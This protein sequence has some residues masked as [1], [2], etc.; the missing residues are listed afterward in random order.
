M[1]SKQTP[2]DL[3][4]VLYSDNHLLALHKPPMLVTQPTHGHKINLEEW[5]KAWIRKKTNKPGE[6]FLHAVH[7]L[8]RE[9]QGIVLFARTSKALSRLNEAMRQGKIRKTYLAVV[10]GHLEDAEGVLKHDLEH[11]EHR[12]KVGKSA[13]SKEAVLRFHVIE[14]RPS[15]TV[16]EIDLETGRYHQIRA[17]FAAIGHPILGDKKYGS[18]HAYNQ[19]GIALWHKKMLFPHPTLNEEIIVV[20]EGLHIFPV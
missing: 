3:L 5:A 9:A 8:D 1:T 11:Q 17:Q 7:R 20:D 6:I 18:R 19:P 13:K 4:V 2:D 16:V 12:A 15:S 10:E 14:K